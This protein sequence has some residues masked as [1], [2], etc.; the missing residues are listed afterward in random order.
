MDFSLA[1]SGC[2]SLHLQEISF[3]RRSTAAAAAAIF[4]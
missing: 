1:A 4:I 2:K 3:A